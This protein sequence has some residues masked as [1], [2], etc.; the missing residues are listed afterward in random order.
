MNAQGSDQYVKVLC[1]LE[2]DEDGYP[3]ATAETL[4]AI[5]VGNGLFQIDNI[6]FFVH[7]IA[8]NDI[9]SATPEEGVFRYKEVVQPSGHGTIRLI[10]SETSDVQAVR[11]L[12]RQLGCSSELSHL[13]HVI[14]VDVPP[15]VSLQEL[16]KELDAGQDQDRWGYEEACLPQV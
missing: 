5:R 4:W 7:G 13:P 12:F 11:D 10:V 16:K 3:P 14:A 8:V 6:P 9:V 1:D 2:Q 15:S